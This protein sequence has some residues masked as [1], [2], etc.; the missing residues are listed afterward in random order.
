MKIRIP[1]YDFA[2]YIFLKEK[3]KEENDIGKLFQYIEDSLKYIWEK[4]KNKKMEEKIIY[5]LSNI[6]ALKERYKKEVLNKTYNEIYSKYL[7]LLK[8]I[9]YELAKIKVGCEYLN[10]RKLK[11]NLEDLIEKV[12]NII[13]VGKFIEALKEQETLP[14]EEERKHFYNILYRLGF[15]ET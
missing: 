1:F 9:C 10:K 8:N 5:I 12:E 13:Y 6:G 15:L 4:S 11:K 14:E 2:E 3:I 7:S